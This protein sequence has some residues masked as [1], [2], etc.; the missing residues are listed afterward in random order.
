MIYLL[1]GNINT[2]NFENILLHKLVHDKYTDMPLF[3]EQY[4]DKDSSSLYSELHDT[5]AIWI[6]DSGKVQLKNYG[7]GKGCVWVRS[8]VEAYFSWYSTPNEPIQERM[9]KMVGLESVVKDTEGKVV[10]AGYFSEKT[11]EWDP[12]KPDTRR[13]RLVLEKADRT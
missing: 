3:S 13:C 4:R 1:Q 8:G 6:L 12:S 7:R 10:I 5:A 2:S 9:V 11:L